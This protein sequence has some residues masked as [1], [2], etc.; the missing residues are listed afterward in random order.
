MC[1][2]GVAALMAAVTATGS[3]VKLSLPG[4]AFFQKGRATKRRK[5]TQSRIRKQWYTVDSPEVKR[6]SKG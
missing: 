3:Q 6:M 5:A 2:L 1:G 4:Y